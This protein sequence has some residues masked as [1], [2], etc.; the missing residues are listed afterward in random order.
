MPISSILNHLEMHLNHYKLNGNTV[1]NDLAAIAWAAFAL[2]H[3]EAE[4]DCHVVRGIM[5]Q[6]DASYLEE[7]KTRQGRLNS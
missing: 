4:C 1:D 3:F 7:E 6:I 5:K 2:M